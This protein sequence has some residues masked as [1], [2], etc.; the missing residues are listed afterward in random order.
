M[1]VYVSKVYCLDENVRFPICHRCK[2]ELTPFAI[3][4]TELNKW[5]QIT[6]KALIQ[7]KL[8]RLHIIKKNRHLIFL[9]RT[10]HKDYIKEI[11]I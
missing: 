1:K 8:L 7:A 4:T 11:K 5:T 2:R 9:C 10:C 6:I 3:T